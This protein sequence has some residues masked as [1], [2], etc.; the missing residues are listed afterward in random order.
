MRAG[1]REISQGPTS[2]FRAAGVPIPEKRCYD[3]M[4]TKAGPSPATKHEFRMNPLV[5]LSIL[6]LLPLAAIGAVL[7]TD[8]GIL[9]ALFYAAV[10]VAAILIVV[11]AAISFAASRLS[12]RANT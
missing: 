8:V 3:R 5:P 2:D 11:G 12:D 7:Y 4:S 10:K 1:R 6:F 9:P